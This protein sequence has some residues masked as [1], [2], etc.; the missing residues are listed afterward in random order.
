MINS[1]QSLSPVSDER[2][3][4]TEINDGTRKST[5]H[6]TYNYNLKYVPHFHPVIFLSK[7]VVNSES[8]FHWKKWVIGATVILALG[9]V[10][11]QH[12][13]RTTSSTLT[14]DSVRVPIEGKSKTVAG[15]EKSETGALKLFDEQSKCL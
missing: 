13:V 3:G 12:T 2:N 7:V 15:V 8:R 9:L 4:T 11:N 5:L 10:A 6:C 14:L 1:Y